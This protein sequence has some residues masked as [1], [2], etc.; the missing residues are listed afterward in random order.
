MRL[1]AALVALSLFGCLPPPRPWL[2]NAPSGPPSPSGDDSAASVDADDPQPTDTGV[3]DTGA[4]SVP[5]Q[6][7]SLAFDDSGHVLVTAQDLGVDSLFEEQSVTIEL[8]AWFSDET[9]SGSWLLAG[10]DGNQA[11]RLAI[12][13]GEL[14]LRAGIYTLSIPLPDDGWN[15]IAGVIDGEN[16][17]MSFFVNG[18]FS[19]RKSWSAPMVNEAS[20]P[21]IH[22]GA[23]HVEGGSWPG[24]LDEV[25]FAN[26]VL[27][28]GGD[29]DPTA[30]RPLD[31][32]MGVWRF[33]EN[34]ENEVTG[35]ASMGDNVRFNDS[36]P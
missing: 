9:R 15:H 10:L 16:G 29:F 2:E 26:S 11:W 20:D 28:D 32:W 27:H 30:D 23:W 25:R 19:G 21:A 1:M 35:V 3:E 8:W 13:V 18:V 24:G 6:C 12:E 31:G 14:V 5:L 17:E 34:L 33:N 36:C 4:T 7:H 22:F